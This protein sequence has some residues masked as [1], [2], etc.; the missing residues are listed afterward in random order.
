MPYIDFKEL[1]ERVSFTDTISFLNLNLKRHATGWRGKCPACEAGGDRALV[2]TEGKG[3][4]CFA[5]HVGGDQIALAAHIL[6]LSAKD[7]AQE[8]ARHGTVPGNSTVPVTGTVP[9]TVP[10]SEKGK[11][12]KKLQ[13]LSYLEADHVAVEAIGFDPEFAKHHGIGYAPKG[14]MRGTVAVPFRD[15]TGGLLGYIG[16]TEATLPADFKTNVVPLRKLA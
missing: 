9:V 8:L 14:T 1:K 15:E 2:I 16:I 7:A 13:P 4:F 5:A 6:G 11:E 10:E 12:T 3:F